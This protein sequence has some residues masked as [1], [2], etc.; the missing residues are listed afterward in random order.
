[1]PSGAQNDTA[2]VD[3]VKVGVFVSE[4]VIVESAEGAVR[5]MFHSL[6][7][8][9]DDPGLEVG[10]TGE[11]TRSLNTSFLDP[12]YPGLLRWHQAQTR[13]HLWQC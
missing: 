13:H 9:V 10:A 2:H 1:M 4:D 3:A 7:E 8:G 6:I 11:V 5:A 12:Y